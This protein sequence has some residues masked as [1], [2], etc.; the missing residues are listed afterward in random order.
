MTVVTGRG[1]YFDSPTTQ[2]TKGGGAAP[3][4]KKRAEEIIAEKKK[5]ELDAALKKYSVDD[6]Y[7]EKFKTP[8]KAYFT[9]LEG[10]VVKKFDDSMKLAPW[11]KMLMSACPKK[12]DLYKEWETVVPILGY[13]LGKLNAYRFQVGLPAYD[14]LLTGSTIETTG[15]KGILEICWDNKPPKDVKGLI[16]P[17]EFGPP[18]DFPTWTKKNRPISPK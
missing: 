4:T 6:S 15:M 1:G 3:K 16:M 11:T 7:V 5:A 8:I 9:V 13:S 2:T 12:D 14:P 10:V 17:K 18:S